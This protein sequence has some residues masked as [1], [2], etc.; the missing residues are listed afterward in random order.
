[1][2]RFEI[3]L[4][5]AKTLEDDRQYKWRVVHGTRTLAESI[6][7]FRTRADAH[8]QIDRLVISFDKDYEVIHA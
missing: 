3:F 5:H 7:E 4:A 6:E 1:M 2:I 8:R